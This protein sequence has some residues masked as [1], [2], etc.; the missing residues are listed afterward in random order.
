MLPVPF[1]A[2]HLTPATPCPTWACVL[3][4]PV[5]RT[6]PVP[7][8]LGHPWVYDMELTEGAQLLFVVFVLVRTVL[9]LVKRR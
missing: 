5:I 1:R 9:A 7:D 2:L 6:I 8:A 4:A 3:D